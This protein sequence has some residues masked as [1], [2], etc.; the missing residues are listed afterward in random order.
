MIF[1]KSYNGRTDGLGRRGFS[2]IEVV[3]AIG[4]ISFAM[5]A[6]VA[7]LPRGLQI[8]KNSTEEMRAINLVTAFS[9]DLE[10]APLSSAQSANFKIAPIPWVTGPNQVAVPNPG[11]SIGTDLLFY[12]DEGQSVS[13]GSSPDARYRITLRYTRAPGKS[14]DIPAT[15]PNSI[16]ALVTVSWPA[17]ATTNVEGR[18]ESYLVFP[19]P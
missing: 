13:T 15:N 14:T 17:A 8:A 6:L 12:A 4:V 7:L 9:S 2:L 11:I 10:S 5:V 3:L 1:T 19:K 16:E 18:V